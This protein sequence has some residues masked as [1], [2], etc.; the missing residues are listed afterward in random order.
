MIV[1]FASIVGWLVLALIA[2][3]LTC[4]LF[5]N[6]T[7]RKSLRRMLK[8]VNDRIKAWWVMA[9]VLMIAML[10]GKL[11]IIFLFVFASFASLREFLTLTNT[12]LAD[13]WALAAA[14]FVVLPVQYF[15]IGMDWYGFYSVFIPVY[16]FLM[17][18]ILTALRGE[19]R[20]F[21]IRVAETQWGLMVAIFCISHLPALLN[22]N[23]DGFEGKSFLLILFLV[24]V[25]QSSDTAQYICGRIWG[26][27]VVAPELSPSKTYEGLVGGVLSAAI[28]GAL[29]YWITPFSPWVAA[30]MAGVV[31]LFGLLGSLVMSAIKRDRGIK[32]YGPMFIGQGGFTDRLDTVIFS[33]PV[34]FHLL[35]FFWE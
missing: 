12:R 25:V 15:A 1:E 7:K 24:I 18:P 14:F 2:I 23:I 28:I 27:T 3:H 17:L 16:A 20:H 31:S 33:A 21:L 13:S 5:E 35:R 34:F 6:F 10:L 19:S 8:N 29:L 30:A 9:V 22:L 32:D 4:E 26:K 11:G